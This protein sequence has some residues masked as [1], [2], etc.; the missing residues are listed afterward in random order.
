MASLMKNYHSSLLSLILVA[1]GLF[2]T[3]CSNEG[4]LQESSKSSV[5]FSATING[6]N[7][8]SDVTRGLTNGE[9]KVNFKFAVNDE[10]ALIYNV[11]GVSTLT[12]ATV[13]S[14]DDETGS[15]Q[16]EAS[17]DANVT[18]QTDV[19]VIY[20]Y[21]A[22]DEGAKTVK[23]DLLVSQD[24]S[25]ET[26]AAQRD[27]RQGTGKLKVTGEG[28]DRE[29]G[30]DGSVT[31]KAQYALCLFQLKDKSTDAAAQVSVLTIYKSTDNSVITTVTPSP[32]TDKLWIMLQPSTDKMLFVATVGDALYHATATAAITAGHYYTPTM[33][34]SDNF[35]VFTDRGNYTEGKIFDIPEEFS[36]FENRGNYENAE[37]ALDPMGS[38]QQDPH[39]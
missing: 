6:E 27:V 16:I 38:S 24:G 2:V 36:V 8:S 33:K 10:I 34:M 30:L 31:L 29:S 11:S 13:T 14:V 19:T 39:M 1:A 37:I 26:I 4:Q 28:N 5:H 21:A 23:S 18:D 7:H 15:A 9:G 20:P 35:V 17:L 22:V 12:K 25:L 32:A 3:S